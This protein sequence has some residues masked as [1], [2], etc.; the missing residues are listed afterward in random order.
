MK[1]G[2]LAAA[3]AVALS[4][5]ASGAAHA[6]PTLDAIKKRGFIQ[7]GVNTG[8]AGFGNP[9][10]AGNWTGLDVDF[11]RAFAVAL[12]GDAGKIKFTPLSA[13]QRFPA[14]QSGEVDVL[15]RNTTWTLTRDTSVGLNF[16]PVTYYDGQGFMVP[17][18]LGVTSAKDLGGATVCV[19]SGT[20]TE[21]NLADYFRA[22]NLQYNPVVIESVDEVNAAYFAGRCD[23]YTTDASG[24]A[25]TRAAVAPNPDDHVILPEVISKEPLAP[26]VRHGD[27]Q[28]FDIVKW[29]VYATVQAEEKGI[30]SKNVDEFLASKD[31]DVLRLLGVS[32][33]M[34][35]ALGLDEKWAYNVIKTI[36]NYGEIYERNV[37]VNTPL[38]LERG[39][40][41]LW[42]NG[43]LMYSMPF[44]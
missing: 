3:A 40:N 34:G 41:A 8:L 19:Q 42:S 17:K 28:W 31:P 36:G 35:A 33:G 12:F 15:S 21:L 5:A 9:D 20:T 11:C 39:L 1:K 2:L 7:C 13:Q 24:L 18:S 32:A 38:K 22:N 37:G 14:L 6:G 27:D 10:S 4:V 29:T 25:G 30:T 43:G 16:A 44:R 26:A 23:V